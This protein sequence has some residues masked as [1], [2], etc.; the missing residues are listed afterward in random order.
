MSKTIR[1]SLTGGSAVSIMQRELDLFQKKI[2]RQTEEFVKALAERGVEIAQLKFST[3]VYAGTNDVSVKVEDE[4]K[5]KK[6]VV[7]MGNAVLFIEFGTGILYP[8]DHPEKVDGVSPR[9]TY[10]QGKGA[11]PRGWA[12]YGDPGNEPSSRVVHVSKDGRQVV[13]TQGSPANKCLYESREALR[14]DWES[15]ARGVFR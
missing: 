12:Y 1:V 7:A 5:N 6:A 10:G 9:G 4:G 14:Q 11:N 2:K 13:K 8:D 15:I 3:A